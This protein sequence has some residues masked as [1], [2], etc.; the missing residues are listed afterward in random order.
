MELVG[1]TQRLLADASPYR[2]LLPSAALYPEA[3]PWLL[4]LA[5]YPD[6]SPWLLLPSAALYHGLLDASSRL[7]AWRPTW[8]NMASP[9]E[10]NAKRSCNS[11]TPP[12]TH[13]NT[14]HT[15]PK[16]TAGAQV[17]GWLAC[18]ASRGLMRGCRT[19]RLPSTLRVRRSQLVCSL[20]SWSTPQASSE[21]VCSSAPISRH[22]PYQHWHHVRRCICHLR[23]HLRLLCFH[24]RRRCQHLVR[25]LL[26]FLMVVSGRQ[27]SH[28]RCRHPW[29]RFPRH[30]Y[31]RHH[32]HHAHLRRLR[33]HQQHR[34]HHQHEQYPPPVHA[35]PSRPPSHRGARAL[36][37]APTSA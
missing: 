15:P 27:W 7:F 36:H 22:Q 13:T 3:S 17:I 1:S 9:A 28:H 26:K 10:R 8:P 21:F 25:R 23:L 14:H 35:S 19:T 31:C 2:L 18:T 37:I 29:R 32:H 11:P 20:A 33:P 4:L 12:P 24:R 34:P 16:L 30:H 5:L 6:A